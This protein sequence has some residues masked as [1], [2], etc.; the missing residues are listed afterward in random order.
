MKRIF[1]YTARSGKCL[2]SNG[3]PVC[4]FTNFSSRNDLVKGISIVS[5]AVSVRSSMIILQDILLDAE[6]DTLTLLG[7]DMDLGIQTTM[8]AVV[9]GEGSICVNAKIFSEMIRRLPDDDIT[10]ETLDNGTMQISCGH[11]RFTL[12]TMEPDDF[13]RLP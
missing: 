10:L 11:S 7:N 13:P 3:D 8:E 1:A 4:C 6:G 12:A 5:K 2:F 9:K